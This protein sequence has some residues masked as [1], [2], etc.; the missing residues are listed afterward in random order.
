M[1]YFWSSLL[2]GPEQKLSSIEKQPDYRGSKKEILSWLEI[3]FS[4]P[5]KYWVQFR[6]SKNPHSEIFI[7]KQVEYEGKPQKIFIKKFVV[8]E[9]RG[10]LEGL[11][12]ECN[13]IDKFSQFNDIYD[14][15]TPKL[16]AFNEQILCMAISYLEGKSFFNEIFESPIKV[17]FGNSRMEEYKRSL[18]NLG[19]WLRHIHDSGIMLLESDRERKIDDILKK[20]IRGMKLRVEYLNK[21]RPADFTSDVCRKIISKSSELREHILMRN[22]SLKVVH[23]DFSLANILYEQGRLHV[24]DFSYSGTGLPERDLAKL[25]L[26]LRNVESFCYMLTPTNEGNLLTSFLSGYGKEININSLGV[27]EEFYILKHTII[28]IYMYARL[29]GSR[30][31]LNPFLCRLFY[32][33]QKKILFSLIR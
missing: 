1:K 31:F 20:D 19:R 18:F 13:A 29:W 4:I 25:Y 33:Y 11:N 22:P 16:Y 2:F 14:V 8:H 28:N 10:Y 9:G 17:K 32:H 15:C 30:R 26:E 27:C 23:G 24:L 21:V 5:Q 7:F 3:L 12:R 6:A